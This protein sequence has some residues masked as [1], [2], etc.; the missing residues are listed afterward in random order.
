MVEKEEKPSSIN[1]RNLIKHGH[2]GKSVSRVSPELYMSNP[3]KGCISPQN[4]SFPW[5][6]IS[7]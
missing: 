1:R 4:E 7:K 3:T 6:N 5:D 2:A